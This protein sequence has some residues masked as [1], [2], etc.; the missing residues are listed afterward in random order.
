MAG[1]VAADNLTCKS[2]AMKQDNASDAIIT[3]LHNT[4]RKWPA[5][6]DKYRQHVRSQAAE[7]A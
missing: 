7:R 3:G 5:G 4:N 6:T 2:T 1:K